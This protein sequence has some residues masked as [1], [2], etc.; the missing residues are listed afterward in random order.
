[1]NLWDFFKFITDPDM[2]WR[3]SVEIDEYIND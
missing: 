2:L 1:M 3:D